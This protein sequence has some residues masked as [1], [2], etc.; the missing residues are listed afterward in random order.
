LSVVS[1]EEEN[2]MYWFSQAPRKS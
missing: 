2:K 1:G